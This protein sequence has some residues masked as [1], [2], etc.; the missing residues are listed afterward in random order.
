MG[1]LLRVGGAPPFRMNFRLAAITSAVLSLLFLAVYGTCN[2]IA[3]Q[4]TDVGTLYFE[5]ERYIPFVPLM[6]IPY[7]SIDLFF[8]AAPFLCRDERELATLWK[9]IVFAIAVAGV[10]F[11]FFPLRF[12]FERPQASGWLGAIFNWFRA[13]DQ[14][15]NL[16][17]SLHIAL[18]TILAYHYAQHTAGILRAA[19]HTWFSLIGVSTLLTYQHH[20]MDVVGG[21]M[22]AGYCFYVFRENPVKL[23]VIGDGKIGTYYAASA[24]ATLALAIV[25]WPWGSLLLWP[26]VALGI[27]ASAYFGVGPGIFRKHGGR[28]PLSTLW[29]L[30]PCLFGQYVSLLH[31]RRQCRPWDQVVPSVMIGRK[32]SDREAAEAVRRGVTAVLDLTAEFSEAQPFL[33][34]R[35]LNVAILDLTAPSQEQ[36]HQVA[37]FIADE[38]QRGTVYVHCKIGYSRSAAAVGAYLLTSG[39][40]ATVEEALHILRTMRPSIVVRPEVLSALRELT[41]RAVPCS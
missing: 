14:P 31:Y 33:A 22:L 15:Y 13:M 39:K 8:V 19:S 10:C 17:P 23:P 9:R 34:M 24:L 32:L 29:T 38:S 11:L 28:L 6:I 35:Y 18:R 20:V 4:Q 30:G 21:F 1:N 40:A 26:A 16:L 12:A 5:W 27:V 36:L 25:L 37:Q 2:Y 3:S 7:M 41:A